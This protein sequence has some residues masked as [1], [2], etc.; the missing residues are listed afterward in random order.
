MTRS[1]P[2]TLRDGSVVLASLI[3]SACSEQAPPTT[4]APEAAAACTLSLNDILLTNGKFITVDANDSVTAQLRIVGDRI[5]A[6]G[7]AAAPA[8]PCTRT[9]DLGGLTV[10]PGLIDN[11]NHWVGRASRPGHHVAQLDSAYSVADVR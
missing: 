11:H 2:K 6:T 7:D 8:G 4:A 9:S 3:A 1:F 5:V 10:I